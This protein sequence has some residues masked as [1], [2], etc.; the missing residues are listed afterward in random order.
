[1]ARY[2]DVDAIERLLPDGLDSNTV[3]FVDY[4][5]KIPTPRMTFATET[6]R[7]AYLV[8]SLKDLALRRNVAVV[9]IVAADKDAL[10]KRRLRMHDMSGSNALMYEADVA[11][12]LNEKSQAVSK[13]HL[14]YD[15]QRAEQAKRYLVVSVEKN[16][17]G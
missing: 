12:V 5:N 15:A 17:A 6:E 13:T 14:A 9:A 10:M 11:L 2:T 1:A 8:Q 4:L 7:T 16:R 3:I